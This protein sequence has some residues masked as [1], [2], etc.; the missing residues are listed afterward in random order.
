MYILAIDSRLVDSGQSPPENV[1]AKNSGGPGKGKSFLLETT[2]KLYP[3]SA[4]FQM[5]SM[6]PKVLAYAEDFL[7]NRALVVTE[8]DYLVRNKEAAGSSGR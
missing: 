4:Y 8:A 2:L 1:H 5:Y 7:Q 3:E 6:S